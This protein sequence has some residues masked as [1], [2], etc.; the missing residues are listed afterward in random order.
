MVHCIDV[1]DMVNDKLGDKDYKQE[2]DPAHYISAKTGRGP[3]QS[4]WITNPPDGT[5]MCA[6]KLIK[7]FIYNYTVSIPIHCVSLFH[8]VQV[9]FRYWGL[10][11]KVERFIHD[12]GLR[13]VMVR[14]H[15]Q[16]WVWQDEWVGLNITDIRRLE[17]ETQVHTLTHTLYMIQLVESTVAL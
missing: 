5:I 13:R 10:Q 15:R 14:A 12:Y 3:L 1:I 6:Y 7:V 17:R 2:E 8:A 11:S 16:A 4:D 9:E